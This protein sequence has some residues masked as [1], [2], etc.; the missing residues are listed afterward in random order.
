MGP[1]LPWAC[2][3]ALLVFVLLCRSA[4]ALEKGA[5][6]PGSCPR[7]VLPASRCIWEQKDECETDSDCSGVAK[8]CSTGCAKF[9]VMP[10][11]TAC[12]QQLKNS[13]RRSKSLSGDAARRVR[14]PDCTPE[15]QFKSVQ[16][17][18]FK[19]FC[20]CVDDN[21]FERPGTRA[22]S[23]ELTNCSRQAECA[24]VTCRMLCPYSFKLDE[25]GC[26][27]CQCWD[28]CQ[29]VQC[30][31]KLSCQL[32]EM[33]CT[34]EPC[35]PVPTCK[36]PRSLE[37]LCLA[38]RPLTFAEGNRP[39]LCGTDPGKPQCPPLHECQV[40]TGAEYGVCCPSMEKALA[41]PARCPAP[42]LGQKEECG[43]PCQFDFQCSRYDTCCRSHE[44]GTH[45]VPTS[46][47]TKCEQKRELAELMIINEK[48]GRGYIPQCASDGSFERRQCSRNGLVCWCVD[49]DGTNIRGTMGAADTVIC[50]PTDVNRIAGGRS[51]GCP[52]LRCAEVC[53][54]GRVPDATGCP[55]C[56]CARPCDEFVC[57]EGTV[58]VPNTQ[59]GCHGPLCQA[60]PKCVAVEPESPPAPAETIPEENTAQEQPKEQ[61]PENKPETVPIAEDNI[62]PTEAAEESLLPL[63]DSKESAVTTESVESPESEFVESSGDLL[64]A[65][66]EY[67][68]VVALDGEWPGVEADQA[69]SLDESSGAGPEPETELV[70]DVVDSVV[71]VLMSHSQ[72]AESEG[73]QARSAALRDYSEPEQADG[74][75]SLAAA[76]Q[77]AQ[78][79]ES[80]AAQLQSGMEARASYLREEQAR[81]QYNVQARHSGGGGSSAN[82]I[83]A[84]AEEDLY[85]LEEEQLRE[86]DTKQKLEKP[87][88]CPFS[89]PVGAHSCELQCGSDSDC[90]G[91]HKCCSTGCGTQC[92]RPLLA[93]ACQ[94]EKS[95]L[96][97]RARS[98]GVPLGRTYIPHCRDQDGLYSEVQC[99]PVLGVCWCVDEAGRE[100]AGTRAAGRHNVNCTTPALSSCPRLSCPVFCPSGRRLDAQGCPTCQCHHPC[101]SVRCRDGLECRPVPVRCVAGPCPPLALCLPPVTDPCPTGRP[102]PGARCGPGQPACPGTHLCHISPF[103]EYDVCCPKPRD[104]CHL[105]ESSGAC[106][107]SLV[108]WRF[109]RD[110]GKCTSFIY[111]G[112]DG[113]ANNFHTLDECRAVCPVL[114]PC[115]QRREKAELALE[116]YKTVSFIPKC[117][118]VTG[119][120]EPIQCQPEFGL[121]WCVDS[122]GR[123]VDG[124]M[125]AGVPSCSSRQGR[126]LSLLPRRTQI[127]E[128]GETVHVCPRSL[129]ENKVCLSDPT[130][131]CRIDPC[132]R[133]GYRFYDRD[134]EEVNCSTGLTQCQQERQQ[135]LN[136]AV[137]KRHGQYEARDRSSVRLYAALL[138]MLSQSPAG[139]GQHH[140]SHRTDLLADGMVVSP[141]VCRE[142][143]SYRPEQGAAGLMW[144]VT[145]TGRPVHS[146]LTRGLV[147]CGEDGSLLER[148]SLSPVCPAGVTPKVC[149]HECLRAACPGHEDAVCVADPCNNC[150]TTFY[151]VTGR[152]VQCERPCSQPVLSGQCRASI[153][154]FYYDQNLGQCEPFLYGGCGGNDNNFGSIEECRRQCQQPVDV[155]SLPAGS[156]PCDESH[157][158]WFYNTV[159][160]ECEPFSYGGCAG[161]ANNFASRAACEARCPDLVLCPH[162][163][164]SLSTCSRG[165][166]CGNASCPARPTATCRVEPCSCQP[167]F[168]DVNGERV[169]CQ[170]RSSTIWDST[171]E[172][173]IVNA[174]PKTVTVK[175]VIKEVPTT[176]TTTSTT[177]STT[178]EKEPTTT[179]TTT[180]TTE[181]AAPAAEPEPSPAAPSAA[182]QY[183]PV[184]ERE[185][186]LTGNE[187]TGEDSAA[188]AAIPEVTFP[189]VS[190]RDAELWG[191]QLGRALR[192]EEPQEESRESTETVVPA[193]TDAT[194]VDDDTLQNLSVSSPAP[195]A[196]SESSEPSA[197]SGEPAPRRRQARLLAGNID[198]Q[199]WADLRSGTSEPSAAEDQY[200]LQREVV[201]TERDGFPLTAAVIVVAAL[202]VT[203][204]AAGVIGAI[205]YRRKNS[206]GQ[207]AEA[208]ST[209]ETGALCSGRSL[210]E[211]LGRQPPNQQ[212]TFRW[213]F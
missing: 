65:G 3:A 50:Q 138:G 122:D 164:G 162:L 61:I 204:I 57:P 40:P 66:E 166:S 29:E 62:V 192:P 104:V 72:P 52:D 12:E 210:H 136:S 18:P 145:A 102:L 54:Y 190:S 126:R 185:D 36:R 168:T 47:K 195:A 180:T 13:L 213:N 34:N 120:W 154:R 49:D 135:V 5:V 15:G 169:D 173:V 55:S 8:C 33:P 75:R 175:K 163:G 208:P 171:R 113:N 140:S 24:D 78:L 181:K 87:G 27:L 121:C 64:L 137:W 189:L 123:M 28:P 44:C 67:D 101:E 9:C 160:Q 70:S 10:L 110:A 45:C 93:T 115:Q 147:R 86:E 63:T 199:L 150:Q 139:S 209:H 117:D 35:P 132:G 186:A 196:P 149:R 144:C 79:G 90:A 71:N 158:R 48:Q 130:A 129:C 156:G 116:L 146:S 161:N 58:C 159:S 26:P 51:L 128:R 207:K 32:E 31:G 118:A 165:Q 88:Q 153:P 112:C 42:P 176:T 174:L 41:P 7:H 81:Q 20:W 111:S 201:R 92:V 11:Y 14:L 191:G 148:Q 16:C 206:A 56:V 84:L 167:Y 193:A 105:P 98:S 187:L 133:C 198:R 157:V 188:L 74:H 194:N 85:L 97:E 127:C 21:G 91:E 114:T 99:H 177:T 89:V 197:E 23:L 178:T 106:G 211:Q 94:H 43:V 39:F 109:D 155:C 103:H 37:T 183:I 6:K 60:T 108:R 202:S 125:V 38:G 96:E 53:Q 25:R 184:P 141:P 68:N 1:R 205:V 182:P 2:S 143:G 172:V 30:P 95:V 131:T 46:N 59:P 203:V 4:T 76:L 80:A 19:G 212:P 152:E 83:E 22:R 100:R 134:G 77:S 69:V 179:T 151:S 170:E 142:D 200:V 124:S 119:A 17:D 107:Q 82:Q 73:Q